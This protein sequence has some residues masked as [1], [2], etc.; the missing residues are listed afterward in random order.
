MAKTHTAK[1]F[2]NGASQAVRLPA[3]FRFKGDQVYISRDEKTNNI[4]LSEKPGA[5]VWEEFFE[6]VR[7]IDI[8]EDWMKDRPMNRIPVDRDPPLFSEDD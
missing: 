2:K 3:E 1:L 7:G 6:F 8:P 4:I 5:G